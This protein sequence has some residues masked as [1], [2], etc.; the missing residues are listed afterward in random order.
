MSKRLGGSNFFKSN[1]VKKPRIEIEQPA[2][3]N[4]SPNDD[5]WGED[6]DEDILTQL[7]QSQSM[8]LPSYSE[9]QKKDQI[10]TSTFKHDFAIPSTSKTISSSKNLPANKPSIANIPQKS[11]NNF[12]FQSNSHLTFKRNSSIENLNS[13][14][15]IICNNEAK[16]VS[17]DLL[18]EIERL[19]DENKKLSE[20]FITKEGEVTILRN[21]LKQT[22][23]TID[24][25]RIEKMQS[26]EKQKIEWSEKISALNTNLNSAKS[27]LE[28][29]NLEVM[30][31]TNRC[32]SLE[33]ATVKKINILSQ[34]Q[35]DNGYRQNDDFS[36]RFNASFTG[37]SNI[38][39]HISLS[40]KSIQTQNIM[41]VSRTDMF[42]FYPLRKEIPED[43]FRLHP[44]IR[45]LNDNNNVNIQ[46]SKEDH[47]VGK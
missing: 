3:K 9:F 28:I 12:I 24:T 37:N 5:V 34:S 45:I 35:A 14:Q 8:C 7:E 30:T 26:L 46:S 18:K 2:V 47:E 11:T 22:Q 40:T 36:S 32:R 25:I 1:E 10:I 19:K 20:K 38:R 27:E 29:K 39:R 44:N 41:K 17:N 42:T 23:K 21:Q 15:T 31:L 4:P 33:S 16:N 13:T 43:I 6:F